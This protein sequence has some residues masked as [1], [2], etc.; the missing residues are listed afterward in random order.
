[1]VEGDVLVCGVLPNGQAITLWLY[2]LGQLTGADISLVDQ[3]AASF[4]VDAPVTQ[5]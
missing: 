2:K 1:M 5:P 3:V 4:R